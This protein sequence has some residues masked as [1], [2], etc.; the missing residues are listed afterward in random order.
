M[1]SCIYTRAEG[2]IYTRAE[3]CI[4]TRAEGCIY[5][6]AESCIYTGGSRATG[7]TRA[8]L[9]A[10]GGGG[11]RRHCSRGGSAAAAAAAS[12]ARRELH[13]SERL[14]H[15][16][17]CILVVKT[18]HPYATHAISAGELHESA[19]R[20]ATCARRRRVPKVAPHT[21]RRSLV[22]GGFR[23]HPNRNTLMSKSRSRNQRLGPR[24]QRPYGR[25]SG[26]RAA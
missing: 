26:W 13:E 11:H 3:S 8:L 15:Y 6:R 9:S 16:D 23:G 25:Y 24:V 21:A 22:C 20:Y 5:T 10:R 1:E 17:G 2:F 14:A 4:Y 19:W 12:A 7:R 18:P